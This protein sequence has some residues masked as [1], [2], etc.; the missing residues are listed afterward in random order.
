MPP[1]PDRPSPPPITLRQIGILVVFAA[2]SLAVLRAN[3]TS[4]REPRELALGVAVELPYVLI[5]PT[6]FLVRRGPLKNWIVAVLCVVPLVAFLVFLNG[7]A[8]RGRD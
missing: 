3:T 6:L 5:L 8:M 1:H 7:V 2:I 4:F